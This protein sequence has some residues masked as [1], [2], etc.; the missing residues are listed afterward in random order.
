MVKV[1]IIVEGEVNETVNSIRKILANILSY[2]PNNVN[3]VKPQLTNTAISNNTLVQ[4][5]NLN[6]HRI[7]E[8]N[9]SPTVWN[10]DFVRRIIDSNSMHNKSIYNEINSEVN[11]GISA[12]ELSQKL[13]I[14][15]KRIYTFIGTQSRLVNRLNKNYRINL[16]NPITYD[17]RN[18][19]LNI[20]TLFS[21]LYTS[22][23][24]EEYIASDDL[25]KIENL[26]YN[27]EFIHDAD[28]ISELNIEYSQWTTHVINQLV[29]SLNI[30]NQIILHELK[31]KKNHQI[32]IDE[33]C[34]N[35][36][37]ST[38]IVRAFHVSV[39]TVTKR[40]NRENQY[41]LVPAIEYDRKSKILTMNP[42]FAA[43]FK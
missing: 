34:D 8:S 25:E 16:S 27:N 33:L 1:N 4:N 6:A 41:T 14:S 38:Q 23:L 9:I 18:K 31:S 24:N 40:L 37:I 3:T 21:D 19:I 26:S 43:R 35:L 30:N 28:Q 15:I 10:R 17:K 20:N 39:I 7:I 36:T 5:K 22:I 12:E 32:T 29:S 2:K 42:D 11:N 13:N